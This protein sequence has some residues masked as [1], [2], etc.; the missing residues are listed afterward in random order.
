MLLGASGGALGATTLYV[1]PFGNDNGAG[2]RASPFKTIQRAIDHA[3]AGDTIQ[4]ADGVYNERL[5]SR[6]A[7]TA[8][9]PITISGERAGS[10]TLT[11]E[12][13]SLLVVSH[14]HIHVKNLVFDGRFAKHDLIRVLPQA[15]FFVL[16]NSVVM[17]GAKDGI[18][19]G[20]AAAT[21]SA[22][23]DYL[24]NV[25]IADSEFRNFLARDILGNRVDAHGIVAGGIRHFTISQ[26]LVHMVSG[27]ALQ[28]ANGNWDDVSVV[29]V[30]F[31]NGLIDSELA[32]LTGFERGIN[33]GENAIDT[34][35]DARLPVRGR[36]S[37]RESTFNG[38]RGDLISNAAALN[39]KEKV[40]VSIDACDL[41][42]NEI[43]MRL[44]GS[45]A[46]DIG[47]H[48]IARNNV[49]YDN[50]KALRV[51]DN[52]R[53][54]RLLN[55]TFAGPGSFEFV[56]G[57]AASDFF[58]AN[59]L[60]LAAALPGQFPGHLNLAVD[61]SGFLQDAAHRFS[62][63]ASSPAIDSATTL[64]EVAVDRLGVSRPQGLSYDYGAFE[65]QASTN[66]LAIPSFGQV[67]VFAGVVLPAIRMM[68]KRQ[69]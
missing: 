48:V 13:A 30:R 64:S 62:L 9:D 69:P 47:A 37:I 19:L 65:Y 21:V 2:T 35:Q 20:N 51:E 60:V 29:K 15:D 58:A 43:A 59:N 50:D 45:G 18:D 28:L 52:L 22:N 27:D 11:F 24:E 55:N 36:L 38:W 66:T 63:A 8:V 34:K 7:G 42:D 31:S 44:R 39:L 49:V 57:G 68:R 3:I 23:F 4:I 33:P 5:R 14:P 6:V 10:A 56:A 61:E 1:A 12:Q 17:N 46:S 16:E 26:S 40:S 32:R 25:V 54:S 53:E 41:F 67:A